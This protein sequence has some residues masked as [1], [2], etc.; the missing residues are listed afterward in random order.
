MA[1]AL[2]KIGK[3][4]VCDKSRSRT[5]SMNPTVAQARASEVESRRSRLGVV[6]CGNSG[7]ETPPGGRA[8]MEEDATAPM[9]GSSGNGCHGGRRYHPR[10]GH[11]TPA[12]GGPSRKERK[13]GPM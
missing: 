11:G 3:A 2:D 6:G 10:A 5:T 9:D 13:P 8:G 1:V 12:A 4:S 7:D